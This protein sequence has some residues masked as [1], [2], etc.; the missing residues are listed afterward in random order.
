MLADGRAI[1][2]KIGTGPVRVVAQT[3][4][5]MDQVQPGDVL[6]TDMTDP[7]W[8]P[9]MKRAAR[10]SPTA[11]GAPATRRS[12]R[13]SSASRRWSAAATRPTMLKDGDARHRVSCAE[14]DT[15]YIYDGLLETE[16]DRGAARRDADDPGQ[17]HDE[18]R[19]SAAGVRLRSSCRTHGV[20]LAR[21][22]FI[23]NNNIGVHPKAILDYPNVDRRPEEGGGDRWRAA[24]RSRARSTST[25]WP[26]ASPRSPRRSGPSR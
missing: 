1:G 11:A 9:V 14:G 18:R 5:E 7:N 15:G 17:D 20:G 6:V 2:Q 8:E 21:L 13:A 22:E 3:S 4:R 10:S 12:S 26:K 25:S 24:M 23:I 19:Q 16:V